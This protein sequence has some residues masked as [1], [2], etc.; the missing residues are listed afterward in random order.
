MDNK[1]KKPTAQVFAPFEKTLTGRL[2]H[3]TLLQQFAVQ[4]RI[5]IRVNSSKIIPNNRR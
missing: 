5:L 1:T 2:Q 3:K 4:H